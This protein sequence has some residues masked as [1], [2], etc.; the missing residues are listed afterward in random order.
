[1]NWRTPWYFSRTPEGMR[2]P[3][4]E[5]L[6]YNKP[7]IDVR[8]ASEIAFLI[9]VKL[10]FNEDLKTWQICFLKTVVYENRVDFM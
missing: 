10:G 7:L 3:G 9:T 1:M 5:P 8:K 2:T 6:L 4:W